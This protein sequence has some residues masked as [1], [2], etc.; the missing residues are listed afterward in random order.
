MSLSLFF[1]HKPFSWLILEYQELALVLAH[2][3][4][5]IFFEILISNKKNVYAAM[6]K[7]RHGTEDG[8]KNM[9]HK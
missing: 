9:I 5:L 4:F 1:S 8:D 3:S 6:N 2:R 7:E